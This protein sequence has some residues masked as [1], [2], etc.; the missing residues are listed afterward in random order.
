MNNTRIRILLFILTFVYMIAVF[1]FSAQNGLVSSRTSRNFIKSV[2]KVVV[3]DYENMTARQQTQLINRYHKLV[4]KGAHVLI[5][6][7][8]GILALAIMLTYKLPLK[9]QMPIAFAGAVLFAAS[10]EIHQIFVPG[11][12]ALLSDVAIDSAG[13]AAGI[14]LAATVK[15]IIYLA[16]MRYRKNSIDTK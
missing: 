11:R 16:K 7:V 14:L 13:A 8:L 15:H 9:F 5:Y 12:G 3:R 6:F 10:D 1:C 2:I 4:R